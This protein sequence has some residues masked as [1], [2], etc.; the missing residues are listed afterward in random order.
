[1]VAHWDIAF[2]D[3]ASKGHQEGFFNGEDGVV[4]IN[5]LKGSIEEVM[6]KAFDGLRH[7]HLIWWMVDVDAAKESVK[8]GCCLFARG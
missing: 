3:K 1:M 8:K 2:H 6:N 5:L 7:Q 4:L